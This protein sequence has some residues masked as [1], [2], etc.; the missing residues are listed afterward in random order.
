MI[1]KP[2]PLFDAIDASISWMMNK[3]NIRVIYPSQGGKS[4]IKIQLKN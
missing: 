3:N 4:G 1:F 2:E